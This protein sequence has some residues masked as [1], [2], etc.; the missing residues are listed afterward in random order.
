MPPIPLELAKQTGYVCASTIVPGKS[1]WVPGTRGRPL[2]EGPMTGLPT[3]P[4]FPNRATR[5]VSRIRADTSPSNTSVVRRVTEWAGHAGVRA[6]LGSPAGDRERRHCHG[7][8]KA[9]K[10]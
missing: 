8:T 7:R 9:P 2:A 3:R 5:I 1:T 4:I 10:A 6:L